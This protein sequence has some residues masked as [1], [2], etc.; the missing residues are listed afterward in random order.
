MGCEQIWNIGSSGAP[1]CHLTGNMEMTEQSASPFGIQ[2]S[3]SAVSVYLITVDSN[4]EWQTHCMWNRSFCLPQLNTE[5]LECSRTVVITLTTYTNLDGKLGFGNLDF[6]A[7]EKKITILV[8]H[9][10][11]NSSTW[12]SA[13]CLSKY[14][15]LPF[16]W[17]SKHTLK[18]YTFNF[19][20]LYLY[21]F[22]FIMFSLFMFWANTI[23]SQ[24]CEIQQCISAV[25]PGAYTPAGR[26]TN[27]W[28]MRIV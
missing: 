10:Q 1:A 14:Q 20:F 13:L 22:C 19:V 12:E 3:Q 2:T 17:W 5:C 7:D 9:D 24:W 23:L 6:S 25:C 27:W 11:N 15:L 21:T 8:G 28:E 26:I 16:I 4:V 18:C